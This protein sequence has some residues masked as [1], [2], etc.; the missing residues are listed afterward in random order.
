MNHLPY[1]N[2]NSY[3]YL[4]QL[5]NHLYHMYSFKLS[6]EGQIEK[7]FGLTDELKNLDE[8]RHKLKTPITAPL[9]ALRCLFLA[10]N[11]L[12]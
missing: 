4:I 8:L 1:P 2:I 9:V 10:F 6:F 5:L 11:S 12:N 7:C 3:M